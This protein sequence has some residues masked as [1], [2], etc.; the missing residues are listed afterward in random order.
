MLVKTIFILLLLGFSQTTTT[1]TDDNGQP[2]TCKCTKESDNG[3]FCWESDCDI[4]KAACF[5]KDSY[6][7]NEKKEKVLITDLIPGDKVYT[8]NHMYNRAE[9]TEFVDYIH[10]SHTAKQ[11]FVKIYF[12]TNDFIKISKEHLIYEISKGY[13]PSSEIKVGDYIRYLELISEE[14]YNKKVI[15]IE[16]VEDIGI[17]AP[18]TSSGH[19]LVNSVHVSAYAVVDYQFWGDIASAG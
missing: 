9:L 17:Y 1:E 16:T 10:I 2:Y 15:K 7:L 13:M 12:G 5:S 11:E 4:Y 18:L 14:F 6:V 19:L 3:L 8:F